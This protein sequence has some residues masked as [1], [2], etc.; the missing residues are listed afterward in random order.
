MSMDDMKRCR[1]NSAIKKEIV[2]MKTCLELRLGPLPCRNVR[3]MNLKGFQG[4]GTQNWDN[5]IEISG[6]NTRNASEVKRLL[7]IIQKQE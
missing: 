6:N 2:Q 4:D 3:F 1:G 5:K 7:D